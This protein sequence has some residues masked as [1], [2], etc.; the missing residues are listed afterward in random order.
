MTN[1]NLNA[2]N[3]RPQV[4]I[5]GAGF[6]GL[7]AAQYL[8]RA[9]VDVTVV[10]AR[11]HQVFQPLLY[12]VATAALDAE[13]ITQATRVML[14]GSRNTR[15]RLAQVQG[16]DWAHKQ[17]RLEDPDALAFDFLILAAGAVTNDFGIPGVTDFGFGLKSVEEAIAIR[18]H[19]LRMFELCNSD[20]ALIEQGYLN[21]VVAGGG[22]TGVEMAGALAEWFSRV[23]RIDFP[24]VDVSRARVIL[25][26]AI[27]KVLAPFDTALQHYALLSLKRRGVDVR[28]NTAVSRVTAESVE[29]KGGETIPTRSV[30]WGTGVKA[31][32]LASALGVELGRGG[33]VIVNPDMSLP[34]K[35][36]VFVIGDLAL[37]KNPDGGPHPQLAQTA[38]QG[39]KHAALQIERL[40]NN[41]ATQPF[42][43]KDPGTMATIGRSAAVAEFPNGL[44][45]TGFIAW[46]MW[47]FLHLV[48]L[49]GFRNRANVFINW[50]WAYTLQNYAAGIL[51]GVLPHH[52]EDTL[53]APGWQADATPSGRS[54]AP[55]PTSSQSASADRPG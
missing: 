29:L 28:L 20:P 37:G 13:E 49:V 26:E 35:P 43:Y 6:G 36:F 17:L 16:V 11:N 14:H 10:D 53:G 46:L 27:D 24:Q 31:N 55:T 21:F 9:P 45:F 15:F 25:I 12:Q 23:M 52:A 34:G 2:Q 1:A 41:E 22:P 4:V 5:V 42:V 33:R 51:L 50:I 39:G 30:I 48:Y 40:L 44:K 7:K 38:L 19:I 8:R 3:K 18:C 32:P 47:L 54:A